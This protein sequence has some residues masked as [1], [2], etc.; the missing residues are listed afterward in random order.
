MY[1]ICRPCKTNRRDLCLKDS[2][3]Y[4]GTT[5]KMRCWC[6]LQPAH[7]TRL[8]KTHELTLNLQKAHNLIVEIKRRANAV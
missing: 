5:I 7:D 3:S 1:W 2:N 6:S 4:R 8:R